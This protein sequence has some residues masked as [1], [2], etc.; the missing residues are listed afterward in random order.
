MQEQLSV[1]YAHSM[2]IYNTRQEQRDILLLESLGFE[3]VNP[4]TP[5]HSAK[6]KGKMEYYCELATQCDVIAFRALPDGS[7]GSGVAKEIEDAMAADCMVIEL[8]SCISRRKL[9]IEQTIEHLRECG[10]R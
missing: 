5:E 9:N 6:A 8:P 1:Y 4:N 3:V 10:Q 2:A 7:I